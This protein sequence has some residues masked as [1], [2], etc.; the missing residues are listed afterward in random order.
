[1]PGTW[2]MPHKYQ[3]W[4]LEANGYSN[5]SGGGS[6]T[7]AQTPAL[8]D[9]GSRF[10]S[11]L[12]KPASFC[13]SALPSSV[14]C[15]SFLGLLLHGHKMA[16]AGPDITLSRGY[17]KPEALDLSSCIYLFSPRCSLEISSYVSWVGTACVGESKKIS[18][19]PDF[20][21]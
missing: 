13:S 8:W 7:P 21:Y 10:N 3:F 16:M 14:C 4:L 6:S 11:V 15:F 9:P 17:P 1:M 5:K 20:Y 2:L 18:V 19:I 12:K